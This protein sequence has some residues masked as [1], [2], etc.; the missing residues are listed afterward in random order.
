MKKTIMILSFV[1]L[2][3]LAACSVTVQQPT[4][5]QQNTINVNGV[6]QLKAVPDEATIV[7]RVITNST[8]AKEAQDKNSAAM[9]AVQ[10]ALKRAGVSESDLET[11]N[12]NL[13]KIT[14]W[15]Y[16][17]QRTVESGYQVTHSLKLKTKEL[18]RVGEFI[19]LAVNAGANDVDNINFGLSKSSE[20]DSKDEALRQ[21]V[22]DARQKAEALADGLGVH[23]GK[24]VSVS[25]NQYN[26]VPYS[27]YDYGED[28][29]MAKAEVAP[30]PPI[31]PK[32]VDVSANV[33]V[34]FEIA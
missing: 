17:K 2:V 8:I 32:D 24:V 1:L 3:V 29:L 5:S 16:E 25:I 18:V 6:S 19:Q 15:D 9:V 12:Y 11:T 13:E 20:K 30:A 14:Y 28:L 21:A 7:L 10:N 26:I 4:Q 22:A 23:L 27:R 34:V 31:Q 33:Q